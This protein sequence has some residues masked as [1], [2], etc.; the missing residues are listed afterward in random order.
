MKN[1]F[2]VL[3]L[4][5]LP[6]KG[7]HAD[8]Q[9]WSCGYNWT[10]SGS[11]YFYTVGPISYLDNGGSVI[12]KFSDANGRA[13]YGYFPSPTSGGTQSTTGTMLSLL[14]TAKSM[15]AQVKIELQG[16]AAWEKDFSGIGLPSAVPRLFQI[17]VQ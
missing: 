15:A 16:T 2:F 13:F 9:T 10:Y 5:L 1:L 17:E 7:A 4:C 12:V 14:L 11:T 3:A 6:F 8:C